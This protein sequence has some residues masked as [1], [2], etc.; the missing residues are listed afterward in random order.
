MHAIVIYDKLTTEL[1]I[2][3]ETSKIAV[4]VFSVK[5]MHN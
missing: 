4:E 2:S 1:D 3:A 5:R